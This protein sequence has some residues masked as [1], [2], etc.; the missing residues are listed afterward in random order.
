MS[1]KHISLLWPESE[2]FYISTSR[3][4]NNAAAESLD[5]SGFSE[6]LSRNKVERDYI[7]DILTNL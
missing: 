5:I 7:R 4:L 2:Q 3:R 6:R 1:G